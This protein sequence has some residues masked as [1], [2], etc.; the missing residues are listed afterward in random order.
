ML[1]KGI[2][3]LHICLKW[4]YKKVKGL[5]RI[6]LDGAEIKVEE[7]NDNEPNSVDISID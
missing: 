2:T 1:I 4:V 7:N 3:Q 5:F 6:G